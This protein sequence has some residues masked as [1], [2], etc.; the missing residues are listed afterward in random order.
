MTTV[1]AEAFPLAWPAG[2]Q[3]TTYRRRAVFKTPFATA[4][5]GILHE[6]RLM[7]ATLPVISSN[8]PLRRDGIPYAGQ[9]QPSD[10]GIAVY[11]MRKGQQ[12]VIACDKWDRVE[13]NMHAIHLTIQ[14]MRGLD[15]WGCSDI[16]D[17]TFQGFTAL[18]APGAADAP[19][20]EVLGVDQRDSLDVIETMWRAKAKRCHPDAGGSHAAMSRLNKAMEDARRAK[21]AS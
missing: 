19:W 13:D 2:F 18:P 4:R 7:G 10:P 16:L 8:V 17:R 3:R 5:D 15:R 20:F 12:R 1:A 9:A 21:A 14:A 6:L 11:F